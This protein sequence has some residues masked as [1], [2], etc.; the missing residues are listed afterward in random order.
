MVICDGQ[1]PI[2]EIFRTGRNSVVYRRGY[3]FVFEESKEQGLDHAGKCCGGH[4]P[5]VA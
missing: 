3:R 4:Q 2:S 5:A 1:C